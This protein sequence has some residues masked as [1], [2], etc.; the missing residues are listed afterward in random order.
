RA[1]SDT[2]RE[3]RHV[4]LRVAAVYAQRVQL[5]DLAGEIFVQAGRAREIRVGGRRRLESPPP[6]EGGGEIHDHRGML[7]RC[8]QHV[9][10]ISADVRTDRLALEAADDGEDYRLLGR[11]REMI[12]PEQGEPLVEWR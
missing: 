6:R 11:H 2:P 5:E 4:G 12:R 9:C 3:S 1:A 7:R 8:E 10:E